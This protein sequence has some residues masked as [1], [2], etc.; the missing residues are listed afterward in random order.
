MKSH[1]RSVRDGVTQ[2]SVQRMAVE[3]RYSWRELEYCA[4]ANRWDPPFRTSRIRANKLGDANRGKQAQSIE[5]CTD[6]SA[7][8]CMFPMS[9]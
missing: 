6:T 5:P 2:N 7:A 8:V 1:R 4:G 3:G 9:P